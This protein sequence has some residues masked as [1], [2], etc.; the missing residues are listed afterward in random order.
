MQDFQQATQ[1]YCRILLPHSIALNCWLI[2]LYIEQNMFLAKITGG[3]LNLERDG[4]DVEKNA[5]TFYSNTSQNTARA[6]EETT[7]FKHL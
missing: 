2:I 3:T 6:K 5:F 4:K 1:E 7:Y